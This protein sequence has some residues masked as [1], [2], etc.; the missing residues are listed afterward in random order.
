MLLP[1]GLSLPAMIEFHVAAMIECVILSVLH[2]MCAHHA[3]DDQVELAAEKPLKWRRRA[4][5]Y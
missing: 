4:A 5:T 2:A 1:D 3:S